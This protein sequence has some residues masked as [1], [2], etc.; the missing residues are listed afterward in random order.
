MPRGGRRP[1]AGRPRGSTQKALAKI[2][3]RAEG[4]APPPPDAELTPLDIMLD[5]IRW[6]RTHAVETLRKIL[7]PKTPDEE[8]K[9]RLQV[10]MEER[11]LRGALQNAAKDAAPYMHRR[12]HGEKPMDE[13]RSKVP[14]ALIVEEE[15]TL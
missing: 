15:R 11:G 6:Y 5:N 3:E 7:D 2:I 14:V 10:F 8:R 4:Q 13:D 1:G 12:L 9:L